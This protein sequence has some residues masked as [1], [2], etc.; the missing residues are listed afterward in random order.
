MDS[1]ITKQIKELS[2]D[3]EYGSALLKLMDF[4]NVTRLSDISQEQAK[5]FYELYKG[6]KI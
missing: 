5:A 6:K 2:I 3:Y 1:K 4:Y